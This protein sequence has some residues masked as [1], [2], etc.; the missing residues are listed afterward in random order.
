MT[1]PAE[2]VVL[3]FFILVI[4]DDATPLAQKD[5]H[6]LKDF[7]FL[8]DFHLFG[9]LKDTLRGTRFEDGESIIHAVRTWL[10]EQERR[11]YSEGMHAL[12]SRWRKA[13]DIDEDY[14][15]K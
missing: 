11:W 2:G 3:N 1:F 15:E 5:L 9:P 4:V 13:V 14:V 8:K 6:L 12:V 10:C 7:H